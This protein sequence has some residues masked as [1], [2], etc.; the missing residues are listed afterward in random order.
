MDGPR[1]HLCNTSL[2]RIA[3]EVEA[4]RQRFEGRRRAHLSNEFSI[5][6]RIPLALHR[7]I[8]FATRRMGFAVS[9]PVVRMAGAPGGLGPGLICPIV[10]IR[11]HT[12]VLPGPSPC[13]LAGPRRAEALTRNVSK[14]SEMRAAGGAGAVRFHGGLHADIAGGPVTSGGGSNSMPGPRRPTLDDFPSRACSPGFLPIQL[15]S[16]SNATTLARA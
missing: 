9:A 5:S 10:G 3:K 1:V 11:A 16:H 13:E 4:R 15:G 14:R 8:A 2:D 6:P 12:F 7:A